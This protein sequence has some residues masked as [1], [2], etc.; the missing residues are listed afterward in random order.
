MILSQLSLYR[1][2]IPL[3]KLLPVGKQRIDNRQGL[4]LRASAVNEQDESVTAEVEIAPLSGLDVDEQP[5]K[6]FSQ[7]SL[8]QVVDQLMPQLDELINQPVDELAR[9]A[10]ETQLPALAFGLSLLHARLSGRL[11]AAR[12]GA[13][14]IPLIYQAQD[15]SPQALD[16]RIDAL[17]NSTHAVKVKVGQTSMEQEV[18]MIHR[19]LARRPDLKL[20]L[21]ANRCFSLEAAIDF[22]A[23]LPLEAIEYIEEPCENPGDNTT[24]YQALGVGFALDETLSSPGY[25]F[26][27][28]PGLSALIVKPMILGS[29][30]DLQALTQEAHEAGVR[31]ILSASLEAS[32][33]INALKDLSE[34]LTPDEVPG[35]DTLSAFSAD[36][37]VSTGKNRCLTLENLICLKQVSREA[38]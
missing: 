28:A 4:V 18:A 9:L 27:I 35:L 24:L 31:V 1:Y 15:E 38:V 2:Q 13:R 5:L 12:R 20:R 37:L 3:D 16:A 26:T 34:A 29:L 22:L 10:Q 17:E 19:I 21:D 30:A 36:L 23:C 14:T 11:P 25:R 7:E 8:S 32:L 6:G 33:G